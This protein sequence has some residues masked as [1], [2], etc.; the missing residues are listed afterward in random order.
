MMKWLRKKTLSDFSVAIVS[1][2]LVQFILF[3]RNFIFAKLL[4]P[5][6]FGVYSSI[7]LFFSYGNYANLGVIDGLSR[8]VPYEI[9]RGSEERARE[10]LKTG[11]WG[12]NF[13][14]SLFLL[15]VIIYSLFSP[16][17]TIAVNKTSVI[18]SAVAVLLNQ[19]FMFALTYYRIWHKFKQVYIYQLVQATLDLV[20][21]LLL[22]FK[23]KVVGIFWGMTFAF[24]ISFIFS[25]K[26][27]WKEIKPEINFNLLKE[28]LSVGFQILLVGFT[29]GFLMS[30]DKFSV[31]NLFEKS[32]MGY[33]S[34]AVGFGVIPYFVS[35]T[36]GQFI[37]QRMVEE[38][39]RTK[40]KESLKIFLDESLLVLGF[41][42]P[43]ISILT[44]AVAEP[45]VYF[46]LPKYIESLNYIAILSIAYY[47]LSLGAMLGT[48]LISVN[49]QGKLLVLNLSFI[50]LILFLNYLAY[51]SGV[52][53]LGIS[54]VTFLNFFIRTF[55]LFILGYGNYKD[56]LYSTKTFAKFF[57]LSLPIFASFIL[58]FFIPDVYLKFYIRILI[59]FVW[60]VI[61]YYYLSRKTAIISSMIAIAKKKV[62]TYLDRV[63]DVF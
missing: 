27:I 24:L 9:G 33:Y 57:L 14:T 32:K 58:K 17:E 43:L 4:G 21:S 60:L 40:S 12:L 20:L 36:L 23:F 47:F 3:F 8:I 16:L 11:L 46:L 39:G 44:I 50:P 45:F 15:F 25:A 2:Y 59:S 38:F 35:V 61:T 41:I 26:N 52:G 13:I 48:F 1:Q 18:L 56:L 29:Y 37:G 7:F 53:L 6:D 42:T 28:I 62:E 51:K 55:I 10:L 19:N 31:A 49:Q 30:A 22:M 5:Y 63:L 34:V 54:C